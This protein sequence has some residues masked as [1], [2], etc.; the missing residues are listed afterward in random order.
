MNNYKSTDIAIIGVAGQFP[1]AKDIGEF[2]TNIKNGVES[3][4]FFSDEELLK[5]GISKDLI[6]S[7][8]YVKAGSFL[9]DKHYF[10]SSFFN[11]LPEEAKLMDPQIRLFHQN[12]WHALENAGYGDRNT[13][14]STGLF[15]GGFVNNNW[16]NYV[17]LSKDKDVD[18]FV[19]SSLSHITHLCSRVSHALNLQ[20][21]SVYI[22]TACSTSLVAVQ[23]ASTSLL[24]REC[25]M[26]LAGGVRINNFSKGG[27]LYETGMI[28]SKDG[29]CRP[30]DVNASG[31]IGG[32]GVGVVVLK[33]LKDALKDNDTIYAIIKGSGINNDGAQKM[34]YTAPSMESQIIAITKAIKMAKV[35]SESVGYIEAHGTGTLLGDPIEVEALNNSYDKST[36]PYCALGSVK[37]NIGHLDVAAGIAGLI[38]TVLILK[39][40]EIPPCIN[41]SE[42]NPKINLQDSPFYINTR[43]KD[44]KNDK[45]PLR[46]GI[47]SL[48]VGGTN[49][50][51]IL[52]EAPPGEDSS[53]S[54]PYHL[55][56][57]SAKNAEALD[58]NV[59]NIADYLEQ[60][61]K[62]KLSDIAYTL[63]ACRT[64]FEHRKMLVCSSHDEAI[65]LLSS[66]GDAK[67]SEVMAGIRGE[68]KIAFMFPGQGS[69]Y[70]KMC[71]DLFETEEVFR[72]EVENCF[73][74][75]QR[76]SGK[77]IK[78]VLFFDADG[79]IH[80]TEFTQPSLFIVEYSLARLLMSWGIH[81][82]VMIGHS[83]GEYV[84]A[85]LAGVFTLEDALSLV[86]K[87]GEL[88]QKM[89]KGTMLS[90]LIS[91]DLLKPYL[92]KYHEVSLAAVNSS[93]S[94]V[95][96]GP[97]LAVTEFQD[98]VTSDGLLSK[99]IST[100]HAFHSQMMDGM[101]AE[102]EKA[103]SN[104]TIREP[105]LS[106][107]S[108]LTGRVANQEVLNPTYWVNHLRNTVKFAEGV[109]SIML[110]KHILFVEVGPGKALGSFVRANVVKEE[111]HIVINLLGQ[112]QERGSSLASVLTGVGELWINGVEPDWRSFYSSEDRHKVALPGYSFGRFKY[113]VDVNARAMIA[114]MISDKSQVKKD[115]S[116]WFYAPTWKLSAN[117][118]PT[119]A[120]NSSLC[121][122]LFA[123][124]CGISE[125]IIGGFRENNEKVIGVRA[126]TSF[127]KEAPYSYRIH[128][129]EE[130]AYQ[131]LY[132]CLAKDN[133]LPNRIVHCWGIT[134]ETDIIGETT[135]LQAK[136]LYFYS[137]LNAF[138]TAQQYKS[139][140]KE[141]TVLTNGLHNIIHQEHFTSP[142]KSLSLG[143]LKVI[144]Q[145]YPGITTGHIDISLS[146]NIDSHFQSTLFKEIVYAQPGKV[147][148]YRNS[149][150]W[151][152][153]YE[154][155][156]VEKALSPSAYKQQGRYLITGGLGG[157]G[158]TLSK[159]L[160]KYF[161]AKLVLLGTAL[162][163]AREEWEQY[164]NSERSDK[165]ISR[166]IEKIRA[167]E[168]E[169]GEVLYFCC[170]ISNR[171]SFSEV[172]RISEARFGAINGIFHS[173]GIIHGRS[174]NQLDQLEKVD[175]ETQYTTKVDGLL[176][177]FKK[178]G[179]RK[180][181]FCVLTSSL[182]SILGGLGFG[183]YSPANTFMDYFIHAYKRQGLL[184]NWVSI[185]LDGINFDD[186]RS[187]VIN[188]QE[189]LSLINQALYLKEFPQLV[190]S[191]KELQARL[192]NWIH[193]ENWNVPDHDVEK[194][195]S[196]E[197][198]G[199][200]TTADNELIESHLMSYE[201]VKQAVVTFL[202]NTDNKK[203]TAFLV[204]KENATLNLFN[205]KKYL[206]TKLPENMIPELIRKI[207]QIPLTDTGKIDLKALV[208]SIDKSV[209]KP[210]K[211]QPR[212]DVELYIA[213]IWAELLSV[214]EIN[215]DDNFF[216]L[217]GHS[218][219][220]V[221]V[222]N[223][224]NNKYSLEMPL[225]LYLNTTLEQ[226]AYEV[227][228]ELKKKLITSL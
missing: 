108:N 181:D 176:V 180:L 45:Y 164:L 82:D 200:S 199:E 14:S 5:E 177:L 222:N 183:A 43:L 106:F 62:V 163:P 160:S 204:P 155:V 118:F 154:K 170:D 144:G 190:V 16:M 201:N 20:G 129:G 1:G 40:K 61:R 110:S 167:I 88:M 116:E 226:I 207:E 188:S 11:Y 70:P 73:E 94:C 89:E 130:R 104:V 8:H 186:V 219:L 150:R 121:T 175:F 156:K 47:T 185:N 6:N 78:S 69:Q 17:E 71:A 92:K 37:A 84:A 137:L 30:F 57:V 36:I 142:T 192:D 23:K 194:V 31:T 119:V 179:D 86:T 227:E 59:E 225:K 143:L 107:I 7:A 171:E 187:E 213:K 24:L 21:P 162:L 148:S 42:L 214:N 80:N 64:S 93:S 63:N 223:R 198:N 105:T 224:V 191:T 39:N 168:A 65:K 193:K 55:L 210:I 100:S 109:S 197:E 122:L 18:S 166:K 217:G 46:A 126:G 141:V 81:P 10:D 76:Q 124:T 174:V 34:S 67:G 25:D 50:H 3:I 103:V 79:S 51:I 211:A 74:I 209:S 152:R 54:R 131:Q 15:A 140:L 66:S 220:L 49:V 56:T 161:K 123:D 38:K 27:Y 99:R 95:V 101:L 12:C 19:S 136:D 97:E 91:E 212:T 139:G 218:L 72:T 32:E 189:L 135:V 85:C 208:N 195:A 158:F 60:N 102:F 138:K 13:L 9:K 98:A 53:S 172:V 112:S 173:A 153:V 28:S 75:V 182:A 44:W 35:E 165:S 77:D 169:G 58:R 68:N 29:H 114:E 133:L 205:I 145:E 202:G 111:G 151:D 120:S 22:N 157:V 147:V 159:Y 221:R 52:E 41:F 127:E 4:S 132:E 87:R 196:N 113:P 125:G 26:A 96:S 2:W 215:L 48:G 203:L 206:R 90:I 134:E 149:C 117:I 83:I 184:K 33:R 115:I 216:D 146:E 128:P 178:L 228:T